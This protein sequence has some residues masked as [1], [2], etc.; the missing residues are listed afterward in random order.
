MK[1][2]NLHSGRVKVLI[3]LTLMLAVFASAFGESSDDWHDWYDDAVEIDTKVTTMGIY[4]V[5]VKGANNDYK[6][7]FSL[8]GKKGTIASYNGKYQY[9]EYRRGF[10]GY[11]MSSSRCR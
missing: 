1:M 2:M 9:W 10:D 7:T 8:K 4:T 3:V 5:S 6:I 11:E